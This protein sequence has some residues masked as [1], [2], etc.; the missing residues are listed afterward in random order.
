MSSNWSQVKERG[1]YHMVVL[2]AT[3][4]RYGGWWLA[5]PVLYGVV[6]Y[7]YLSRRS[8]R[9]SAHKY[10]ERIKREVPNY[11]GPL[12]AWRQYM[13]FGSALLDRVSA[14]MG[15]TTLQNISFPNRYQLSAACNDDGGAIMLTAHVGNLE[16]CR[17]I[18]SD[19]G[20]FRINVI[21]DTH[22]TEAFNKLLTQLDPDSRVNLISSHNINP[23]TAIDLNQRLSDGE[24]L[25]MMA[26]REAASNSERVI[27]TALLGDDIRLPE[28]VFRL[29]LALEK[30]IFFMACVKEQGRNY[31]VFLERLD[32]RIE[33]T[34][35]KQR[36]LTLAKE[37]AR[38]L[39]SLCKQ[40]P[41]QWFNFYDYW[42][43]ERPVE[44]KS[45]TH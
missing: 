33:D 11:K 34:G 37:Y 28:G 32:T 29:A 30:P 5:T 4:Y 10:I 26:D 17:A 42:R 16:M 40:Y 24:C 7:F 9:L 43:E 27:E 44:K 20:H 8:T 14:W 35:K 36:M 41:L 19:V 25:I 1:N 6:T 22:Q 21:V 2:M 23:A 12:S 39:Q 15:R 18:V 38:E 31:R 13:A 45:N 3:I